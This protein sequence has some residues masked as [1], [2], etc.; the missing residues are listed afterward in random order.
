MWIR[1]KGRKRVEGRLEGRGKR[2]SQVRFQPIT[3][4]LMKKTLV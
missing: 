4:D 1:L 3:A 2:G